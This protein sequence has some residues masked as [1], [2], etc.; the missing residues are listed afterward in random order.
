MVVYSLRAVYLKVS[1]ER[2]RVRSRVRKLG[3]LDPCGSATIGSPLMHPATY[4]RHMTCSYS[5]SPL[6]ISRVLAS[7]HRSEAIGWSCQ[8]TKERSKLDL[9]NK[10]SAA[11]G[12]SSNISY[13]NPPTSLSELVVSARQGK[14]RQGKARQGK[15]R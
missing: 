3:V 4:S 9:S 10:R 8:P 5:F 1:E 13:N 7:A 6:K 12:W 11:V 15:V 2:R 14:A